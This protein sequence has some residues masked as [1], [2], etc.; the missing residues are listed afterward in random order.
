MLEGKT[1]VDVILNFPA[2]IILCTE[3]L[4]CNLLHQLTFFSHPYFLRIS[5]VIYMPYYPCLMLPELP[6]CLVNFYIP[7]DAAPISR[8]VRKH[9]A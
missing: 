4:A 9:W 5:G 2:A 7:G 8:S 3:R 6:V 1:L